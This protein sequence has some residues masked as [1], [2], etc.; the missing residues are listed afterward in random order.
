[1]KVIWWTWSVGVA[2]SIGAGD[3]S[4]DGEPFVLEDVLMDPLGSLDNIT[5]AT[6]YQAYSGLLRP[7]IAG[8]KWRGWSILTRHYVHG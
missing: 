2:K 7:Q 3:D 4:R 6:K 1:M 5:S 8:N